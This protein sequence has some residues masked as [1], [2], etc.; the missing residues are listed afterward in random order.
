MLVI[1]EK[2]CVYFAESV[3]MMQPTGR[4]WQKMDAEDLNFF[5]PD[6][7][8]ALIG[9]VGRNSKADAD[10]LRYENPPLRGELNVPLLHNKVIP[11]LYD[12]LDA[13]GHLSDGETLSTLLFAKGGSA[14]AVDSLTRIVRLDSDTA[15]AGWGLLDVMQYSL[16]RNAHLP[17]L[18]RICKA[19]EVA[20]EMQ[21]KNLFPLYVMNTKTMQTLY[22]EG[23]K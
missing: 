23:R 18:E 19:F 11:E 3:P 21:Q 10:A 16:R 17:V 6:G 2:D 12:T 9:A 8:H 1:V 14:Y 22:V 15:F 4:E 7:S 13:L 5:H 20:G